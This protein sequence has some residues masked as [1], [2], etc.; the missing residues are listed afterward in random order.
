MYISIDWSYPTSPNA[1]RLRFKSGCWT[2][3]CHKASDYPKAIAGFATKEEAIE[4][5]RSLN[6]P[7]GRLWAQYA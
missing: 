6:I 4:Y 7:F 2:V 1:D 3:S 5:A